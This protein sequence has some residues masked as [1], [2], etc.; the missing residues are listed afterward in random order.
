MN[1]DFK[2][3][4]I[5]TALGQYG[6]VV[7]QFILNMILSRM[8]TP[9][10][11]GVVAII[12]VFALFFQVLS[13]LSIVPAIVQN[14]FLEEK[15][16]GVIFNY[17]IIFGLLMAV[18]FGFSGELLAI[19]FRDKIYISL[20][21]IMA[22]LIMADFIGSVPTAILS[23][24]KEFKV[25]NIR[26]LIG[27]VIG[28]II[29]IIVAFFHIG[30]YALLIVLIVPALV[31]L[32]FNLF[33]VRI[34]YT[35]SLSSE[36]VKK[37][38]FFVK[39]QAAFSFINYIYR[40]LDNLLIGRYLGATNLGDYSKSYQLI[41]FPIT[42]FLGVISPVIQPILSEHEK[43]KQLIKETYLNISKLLA[44]MAIP[45]SV[46]LCLNS[47]KIIYLLFGP[48]WQGAVLPFSILCL[49]IWAQMLAQLVSVIWQSRNL[50]RIQMINGL[51]SLVIIGGAIITGIIFGNLESVAL[52]VAISYVINFI[53]SSG[54]LLKFGLD[55]SFWQ[56][57]KA[58]S[59]PLISGII[60]FII[61]FI[62]QPYINF[63]SLFLTLF[64][65][66]VIW[67]I[68]VFVLLIL[69]NDLQTLRKLTR[70]GN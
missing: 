58:I 40:N 15:D 16:Y 3:G 6:N 44:L 32:I 47:D 69:M 43:N 10:E 20:S 63:A 2:S 33:F 64:A 29:G 11:F 31:S 28:A 26:L 7:I 45:L 27:S 38:I 22:I 35:K 67:L 50:P 23:K 62:V 59:K 57:L 21:W 46:F 9:R 34:S 68:I 60:I 70:A 1:N 19:I 42:V 24:K 51:I 53:V 48:Q 4:I 8:L 37:I 54:M 12:Q 56:M 49:S 36:P 14:K 30:I 65:R 61:L 5:F 25:I 18:L 41:S 52:A 13:S 66:G 17:T 55:G 39:Y